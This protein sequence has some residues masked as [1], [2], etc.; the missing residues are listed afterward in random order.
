MA[1]TRTPCIH[2]L[3]DAHENLVDLA[4]ANGV[5]HEAAVAHADA[6][7]V[8]EALANEDPCPSADCSGWDN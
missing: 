8:A 3:T 2:R 7:D 5:D 4:Q 1:E 6:H